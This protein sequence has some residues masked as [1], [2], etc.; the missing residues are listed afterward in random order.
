MMVIEGP[1][2]YCG[3]SVENGRVTTTA[4]IVAWMQGKTVPE[5]EAYCRRKGWRASVTER[6][7]VEE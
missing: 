4:P 7:R 3:V 1:H 6:D 2:F 5:V